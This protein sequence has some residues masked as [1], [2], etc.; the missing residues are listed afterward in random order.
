MIDSP[1]PMPK[2]D[3]H[4]DHWRV[5]Q[6]VL[7]RHVPQYEVWAFGSR[8][9]WT[10]KSFS[11]LDIAIITDKPL[12]L[13]LSAALADDF[14]DSILPWKVDVVD[15]ANITD[16]FR[17]VIERDKV[18]IQQPKEL[19]DWSETTLG[20]ICRQQGGSIQT[21][22]FG[23]QLHASD[24]TT[25]GTPVVMP[26]NLVDGNV[27]EQEIARVPEDIANKLAR[28]KLKP[29]DIVF[30]RRGDVT[31]FALVSK[32]EKDWLC[33]TGCL[34][35]SIGNAKLATPEFIAATLASPDTKEWLIRHAVGAT[36]PNL[37]TEILG[38]VPISL[39]LLEA[40]AEIGAFLGA[41]KDRIDNLRQSNAT[42]EAIT[43]ALFKSWFVDF[44]PVRAKSE[45][46][47][48]EG[49]DAATAALFPGE[50]EES[51]LGSIPKGWQTGSLADVCDLNASK[52]TA[53]KHPS[54]LRYID[55]SGVHSNRID[56]PT[57]YNFHDAPSRAR[58]HLR[59]GDTIIGTVRPG[60]RA[61]AYIHKPDANLTGSTGFAVLSPK[62]PHLSSFIY[63]AA[64]RSEAIDRL[65]NLADG[66]AYPAVRPTVVADTPCVIAGDEIVEAFAGFAKPLLERIAHNSETAYSLAELRDALLPRLISGQL[67]LHNTSL[68]P[69]YD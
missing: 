47:E 46:R 44:D 9:K 61:F 28:H 67:Q 22:P 25:T 27:S 62:A 65:T 56:P 34:K 38:D 19:D 48:P 54:T 40:Q 17:K 39:P 8:V 51:E 4:P 15:W 42:L 57:D 59:E 52:W 23:S 53:R 60:N 41:L 63:L 58:H 30:S 68:P 33:G 45:G 7:R 13:E 3:M 32:R 37:N 66:G 50:F 6:G 31:R 14:S 26:V 21:G 64:T 35:V 49:M 43:Q 16:S 36:M 10:A 1:K 12:S 69:S 20:E 55:L 2:V 29:G 24:Y 5:V 18:L 11:D